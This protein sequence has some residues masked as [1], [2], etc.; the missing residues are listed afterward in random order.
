MDEDLVYSR[1]VFIAYSKSRL[2][3]YIENQA[4]QVVRLQTRF[5]G[6]FF[7]IIINVIYI[8]LK[9]YKGSLFMTI[10]DSVG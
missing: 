5:R 7:S 10:T 1:E 8:S 9:R 4:D 2:L 6:W 3:D